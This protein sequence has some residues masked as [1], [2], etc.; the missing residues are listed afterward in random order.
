[1]KNNN[2][3][4]LE[5][6]DRGNNFVTDWQL[7]DKEIEYLEAMAAAS[8]AAKQ[9]SVDGRSDQKSSWPIFDGMLVAKAVAILIVL[10]I[11]LYCTVKI[12]TKL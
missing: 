5:P 10:G 11:Y 1:M 7:D 8:Q 3:Q 9:K 12:V 4:W 2:T 6:V